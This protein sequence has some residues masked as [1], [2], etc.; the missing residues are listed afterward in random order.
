MMIFS[1]INIH[2]LTLNTYAATYDQDDIPRDEATASMIAKIYMLV[3]HMIELLVH[4]NAKTNEV[5][6][7]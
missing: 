4:H 6:L 5:K 3:A 7:R 1:F 2:F